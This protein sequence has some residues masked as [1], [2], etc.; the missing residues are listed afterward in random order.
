[1]PRKTQ[2]PDEAE[3]WSSAD[4]DRT[5]LVAIDPGDN[6]VGVAFFG[7]DEDGLWYCQDAQQVDD[8]DQFELD[9][10]EML[11]K[12]SHPP[13]VVFEIFRLYADKAQLQKGSQF[14]TSQQIGA[15]KFI[16]R[17]RNSHVAVHQ[18][19]AAEGKLASCELGGG[20]CAA[21]RQLEPITIVGQVADIKK[22]AAGILRSKGIKSVGKQA[23]RENTGWGD[24]CVDAELHGWYY[25]LHDLKEG[26]A[27]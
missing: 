1:M 11:L 13:I 6:H 17:A 12:D 2:Q 27:Q 16:V 15:I 25:I 24:H 5:Q 4:P 7:K 26:Y 23:K 3:V 10:A 19:A 14:R 9:L 18:Q 20:G 22:P 8:P 21:P